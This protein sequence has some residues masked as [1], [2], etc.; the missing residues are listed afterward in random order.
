MTI[1]MC[2]SIAEPGRLGMAQPHLILHVIQ[3]GLAHDHVLERATGD[4][5][6]VINQF[7]DGRQVS[8]PYLE[9]AMLRTSVTHSLT[10]PACKHMSRGTCMTTCP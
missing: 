5:H 9:A 3:L 1:S 10:T 6:H 7:E 2:A 4:L 8:T